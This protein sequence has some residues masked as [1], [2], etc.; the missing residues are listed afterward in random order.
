M[1]SPKFQNLIRQA[2]KEGV[3]DGNKASKSLL[4]A[5]SRLKKTLK[6]QKWSD[7]LASPD[8]AA[9]EAGLLTYLFK[10]SQENKPE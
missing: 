8:R 4:A 6:F 2:V 9:L 5:E 7:A 3:I 1:S 10:D